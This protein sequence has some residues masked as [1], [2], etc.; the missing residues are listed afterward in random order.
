MKIY[1]C[2]GIEGTGRRDIALELYNIF[3]QIPNKITIIAGAGR[4]DSGDITLEKFCEDIDYIINLYASDT[5]YLIFRFVGW[6]HIDYLNELYAKYSSTCNFI[7]FD[8]PNTATR[9]FNAVSKNSDILGS[10]A[11]VLSKIADQ[12]TVLSTFLTNNSATWTNA[13]IPSFNS[14]LSLIP[15]T[16]TDN[17]NGYRLISVFNSPQ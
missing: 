5:D 15:A 4:R 11:A 10:P 3:D 1:F 17:S 9:N 7:L 2:I 16:D 12:E 14:D 13:A 6:A 8:K